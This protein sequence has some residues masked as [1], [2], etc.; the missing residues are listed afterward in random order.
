MHK[1]YQ[2]M[3]NAAIRTGDDIGYYIIIPTEYEEN[4]SDGEPSSGEQRV[5]QTTTERESDLY[6]NVKLTKDSEKLQREAN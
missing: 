1:H 5:S 4:G 3:I 2:V 6:S